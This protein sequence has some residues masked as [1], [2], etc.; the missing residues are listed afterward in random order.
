LGA[1]AHRDGSARGAAHRAAL[2]IGVARGWRGMAGGRA[3]GRCTGA[4]SAAHRSAR[5]WRIRRGARGESARR[6]TAIAAIGVREFIARAAL[7]ADIDRSC[8]VA[9]EMPF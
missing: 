5:L 3:H 8:A 4:Q 1:R 2:P 7:P 6:A 9:S